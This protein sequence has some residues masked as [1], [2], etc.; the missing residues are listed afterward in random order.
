VSKPNL[1]DAPQNG[2]PDPLAAALRYLAAGLSVIPIR[3]DGSKAPACDTWTPYQDEPPTR[4]QVEGWFAGDNPPGVAIICGE[5]SGSL[6]CLDFDVADLFAPWCRLVDSEAPGLVDRLSI[7]RTP[8]GFHCRYRCPDLPRIPGNTRLAVDPVAGALIESRG[9]GGYALAPGSPAECH[10]LGRYYTEFG[11]P[12]LDC[13]P[14]IGIEEREVLIRCARSFDRTAPSESPA[15]MPPMPTNGQTDGPS[16]GDD[17]DQRGPDWPVILEP[18]GWHAVHQRGEVT[19]WRRPNKDGRGWSATTGAC[20]SQAGRA[21][22]FVFSSNAR[23]FEPQKGYSKFATYTLLNHA[24]DFGAAAKTLAAAGYGD[25]PSAPA[26]RLVL[27][28]NAT[29]NGQAPREGASEPWALPVP[30]H[31]PGDLPPFPAALLPP[32]LAAWVLAEAEATQTPPDLA[33]CLALAVAGAAV[34]RKVRVRIRDGWT[35]PADIFAVVSLPPAERKSAV[36]AH[37]TAPLLDYEAAERQRMA[38]LIAEKASEHRV[39]EARLKALETKLAK[40]DDAAEADRL[41]D[42]IKRVVRELDEHVVPDPPQFF[43]D[44]VTPEALVRLL[45]R[46]GGRMLLASAEGTIFEIAKG[47]YSETA[48]FDVFLKGHAGDPL[49]TDRVNRGREAVDHPALSCALAVQPD[50]IA[51]LAEQASLRGRGF[52]ARWLYALPDSKVGQRKTAPSPVPGAVAQDYRQGMLWLWGLAPSAVQG[53]EAGRDLPFTEGA[54]EALREL[55]RRLEPRLAPG[56]PMSYL[57]GWGG[58]LAGACARL[59]LILHMAATLGTGE[60]WTDLISRQTVETALVLGEGYFLPHA[61]AAFGQMGANERS[62]D[63]LRVVEWLAK[64]AN[65]ETLKALKGSAVVVKSDIHSGVFGGSRSAEDV[66]AICNALCEH[67]YLRPTVPAWRRNS[68][69]FEVNPLLN[70]GC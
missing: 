33:G 17:F 24:S 3:R 58:K 18:H 20:T 40:S 39:L 61:K 47:R 50:V 60:P 14:S 13:V 48:N 45:A 57:A 70:G 63:A 9:T 6:E 22:F 69:R 43:C 12:A 25:G 30:F 10:E 44:D 55:E 51:G 59:S 37:A 35:E 15:P 19:Y 54:D 28:T 62:Q 38:P 53:Q 8:R 49:R 1:T 2:K 5:V 64:R 32:W 41:R 31:Q 21:L 34:A 66:S 67:G 26:G 42:E 29:V 4:E 56:E 46:Q 65:P 27:G 36:F 11:G 23:P 7:A 16:P 52:L 68:Q